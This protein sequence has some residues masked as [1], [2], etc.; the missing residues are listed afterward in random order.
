MIIKSFPIRTNCCGKIAMRPTM[1]VIHIGDEFAEYG[2]I[3]AAHFR[4]QTTCPHCGAYVDCDDVQY[5]GRRFSYSMTRYIFSGLPEL[6]TSC[7]DS[8]HDDS[9]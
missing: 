1:T 9:V 2:R 3:M 7:S 6:E 4:S 8:G 5:V